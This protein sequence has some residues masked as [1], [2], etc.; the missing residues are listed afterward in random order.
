MSNK[1]V[2]GIVTFLSKSGIYKIQ[3]TLKDGHYV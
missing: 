3:N 1:T 2:V